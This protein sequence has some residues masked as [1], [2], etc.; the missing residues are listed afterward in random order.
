MSQ[1]KAQL[2]DPVDGSIV[3]ADINASAAI[4]GSKISPNFGSQNVVTTG[5]LGCGQ[6]TTTANIELSSADP[7]IAF[8]DTDNNDDFSIRGGGGLLKVRSDTDAADRLVINSSGNVGIGTASPTS[9]LDIAGNIA[10]TASDPKIFFN[11]GGSM[12]SNA[13]VANTLAF[14][15]DG[16]TERMRINSSGNIGI[17]TTSPVEKLTVD[18]GI[19]LVTANGETNRITS[20]PS[21]SYTVGVSGGAAIGFTRTADGGGGS[22]QI[23]FETHHQ[24]NSHGERMRIDKDGNVGIGTT[25]PSSKL[26]VQGGNLIV[27]NDTNGQAIHQF[28]NRNTTSGSSAMTSELHFNF[29]RTGTPTMNLSAARII[30]GK[31][32]E[33]VGAASNQDGFL[34]FHTCLNETPTERM[35]ISSSGV[36]FGATAAIQSEKYTFFRP[37]SEGNTLAYFHEGASADVTGVIFRHGRALSG[38]NGKQIGFLRNDGT[39]VGSIV[40]GIN[41]TGYNTSSDY[42]LKENVTA[43]SDGITRLKTLKPYKFN[44]KDDTTKLVVDGFFAHE[45]SSVVPIA[46][47]GTKDQVDSENN[48]V[49]QGID[50]SKLVPLLVAA[51]QE[52]IGKVEALEAA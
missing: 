30:A 35:R 38:F 12:I 14:F 4:A 5:T 32:R 36:R 9:K 44:F 50:Q 15:T 22:D 28:Q 23:I 48:P 16:S 7:I 10:L 27:R 47:T 34:A 3:N 8:T 43:I 13:N 1:T 49:Y 40:S 24:G 20:L 18:G 29:A 26:N 6:I 21:G 17:G 37:E 41:S 51:V 45:V 52:L 2:I 39:E 33:W 31:E 11:S 25:S 42:R 19:R 46:V